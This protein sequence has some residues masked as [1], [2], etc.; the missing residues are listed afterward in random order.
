MPDEP[1]RNASLSDA[2]GEIKK[3]DEISTPKP[4]SEPEV[5]EFEFNDDGE[6]DLRKTLKKFRMWLKISSSFLIMQ[7]PQKGTFFI[8]KN[9]RGFGNSE[10][11]FRS[12]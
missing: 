4:E 8:A 1:A 12:M 10:K 3:I 11:I 2:G 9:A 5:L 6:E 7:K